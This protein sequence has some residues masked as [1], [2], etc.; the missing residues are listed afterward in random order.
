MRPSRRRAA[1]TANSGDV[2]PCHSVTG[3]LTLAQLDETLN[4]QTNVAVNDYQIVATAPYVI[5]AFAVHWTVTL[6]AR[7][8]FPHS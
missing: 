1:W 8:C 4:C 5:R 2:D 7:A 3:T 6:T